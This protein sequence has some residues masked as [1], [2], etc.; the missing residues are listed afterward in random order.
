MTG[1]PRRPLSKT[2]N[3]DL[4]ATLE[5]ELHAVVGHLAVNRWPF[6]LHAKYD[7]SI[8]RFLDVFEGV[9]RDIPFAGLRWS[10]TTP[11]RSALAT[12]NGSRRWQAVV[13]RERR[14]LSVQ[15]LAHFPPGHLIWSGR[16][17]R[18]GGLS[19]SSTILAAPDVALA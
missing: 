14:D 12:S 17:G 1:C 5:A 2:V 11:K 8:S 10:S 6:R 13:L 16:W 18:S 15:H 19:L 4:P 7:E 9:N 3:T